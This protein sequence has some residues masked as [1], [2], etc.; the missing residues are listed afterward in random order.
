MASIGTKDKLNVM[1]AGNVQFMSMPGIKIGHAAHNLM[2]H[3]L[4]YPYLF[5]L[6]NNFG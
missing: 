2:H 3:S 5:L 4:S 1:V 6:A